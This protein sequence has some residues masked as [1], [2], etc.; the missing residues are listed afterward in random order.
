MIN[1]AA[2]DLEVWAGLRFGV[3]VDRAAA[4][5][6]QTVAAAIF[7]IIGGRVA[8]LSIIGEVTTVIQTQANATKLVHNP[9][10]AGASQDLC[11]T[12]DITADAVGT[13]YSIT[14]TPAT[15]LQDALN[16]LSPN[17]T[18]PSPLILKAGTIELNCAGSNTGAVKWQVR[19]LPIDEGAHVEVA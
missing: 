5:L 11:A 18:L 16:F 19:Y 9:T 3:P 4:A 17:K 10:D 13:M 6:P 14:G 1:P 15:A 8:I 2:Q 7:N 12:V